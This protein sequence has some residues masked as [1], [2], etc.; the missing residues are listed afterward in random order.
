M[1]IYIHIYIYIY[2][3]RLRDLRGGRVPYRLLFLRVSGLSVKGQG[4]WGLGLE[5]S[6]YVLG[7][8]SYG[9]GCTLQ[10]RWVRGLG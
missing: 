7:V 6:V 3:C 2:G 1:Y 4:V 10:G 8:G 9:A 5:G